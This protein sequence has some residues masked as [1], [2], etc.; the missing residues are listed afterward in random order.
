MPALFGAASGFQAPNLD[1]H[2]LAPDII[3]TGVIVAILLADLVIDETHKVLVTN[4][5][6]IGVLAALIPIF[7]LAVDGADP[8]DR[9]H[10]FSDPVQEV[11]GD[12][13][14]RSSPP[15]PCVP[16]GTSP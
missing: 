16:S 7:T 10:A 5:A 6:G 1:Y 12:R 11:V 4:L 14:A 15:P 13:T 3:L 2:A 9:S 8:D